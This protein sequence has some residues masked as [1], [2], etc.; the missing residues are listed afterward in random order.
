MGTLESMHFRLKIKGPGVRAA[1]L[2]V[3]CLGL[4]AHGNMARAQQITN[5]TPGSAYYPDCLDYAQ[6]GQGSIQAIMQRFGARRLY[7]H[8]RWRFRPQVNGRLLPGAPAGLRRAGIT[9]VAG[10]GEGPLGDGWTVW[11]TD[12]YSWIKDKRPASAARGG[13][14]SLTAG[15]DKQLTET[16]TAGISLNGVRSRMTTRFNGGYSHVN[17]LTVSPYVNIT[18]ADWLSAEITGGYVYNRERLFRT[19]PFFLPVSGRR[20]SN[21]YMF[22]ASLDASKWY[23]S[24]LLSAHGGVVATRDKWT[25]YR[26]SDGTPNAAET[27]RLVQGIVE[28]TASYWL[29]PVM[30]YVTVSYARDLSRNDPQGGD[31]DDWTFTGGLAWY[32]SGRLDGLTAD[33]SASV[34]AGRARQRNATVSFGLRWNF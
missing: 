5:C 15:L 20:H 6:G 7:N 28:G 16:L 22:S 13:S 30:P 33:F 19:L 3:A 21:G 14:L 2:T 26:E 18:L 32:G 10:D 27:S 4:F 17:G 11:T 12:S 1:V 25:A 34:V 24:W 29:E 31:R 23:G 9:P 8:L